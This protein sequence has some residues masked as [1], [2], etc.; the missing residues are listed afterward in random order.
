MCLRGTKNIVNGRKKTEKERG[1]KGRAG[2]RWSSEALIWS[3]GDDELTSWH[4]VSPTG[5]YYEYNFETS[6]SPMK[7]QSIEIIHYYYIIGNYYC[8]C[9]SQHAY[10]PSAGL[11]FLPND[12]TTKLTEQNSERNKQNEISQS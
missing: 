3:C 7:Y 10:F 9:P 8:R 6:D 2:G 5:I 11:P 1:G 4:H 12:V